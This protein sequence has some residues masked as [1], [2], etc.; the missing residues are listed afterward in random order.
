MTPRYRA[1]VV[2]QVRALGDAVDGPENRGRGPI[3]VY[4]VHARPP[5]EGYLMPVWSGDAPPAD[6]TRIKFGPAGFD[7]NWCPRGD[8]HSFI[9]RACEE[10]PILLA[11]P[12]PETTPAATQ[13]ARIVM[14]GGQENII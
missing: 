2:A 7:L 10:I 11:I 3:G 12:E 6:A 9:Y 14:R 13:P 8:R 5:A 1:W 4:V